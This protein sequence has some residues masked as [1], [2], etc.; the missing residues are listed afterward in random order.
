MSSAPAFRAVFTWVF[1][2]FAPAWW[3]RYAWTD[4]AAT[5]EVT[6]VAWD[7]PLKMSKAKFPSHHVGSW[8][9]VTGFTQ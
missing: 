9:P 3:A 2:G 8:R 6:G 4:S 5:P 1:V 7:V